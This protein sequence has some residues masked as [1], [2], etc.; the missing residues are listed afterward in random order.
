MAIN[1]DKSGAAITM[2]EFN[3]VDIPA[4]IDTGA[5]SSMLSEEFVLENGLKI[6]YID[7]NIQFSFKDALDIIGNC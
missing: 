6:K 2:V 1:R 7:T 3:G 4:L 5:T